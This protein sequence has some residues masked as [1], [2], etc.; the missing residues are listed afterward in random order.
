[1]NG[2]PV[3]PPKTY[4]GTGLTL[5]RAGLFLLLLS[6]LGLAV[7]WDGG[8]GCGGRRGPVQRWGPVPVPGP[9]LVPCRPRHAGLRAAGATAP[10]PRGRALRQL[11]RRRRERFHEPAR[12]AGAH[13]PPLRQLLAPQ[14]ALPR[15]RQHRP[16][17]PL[18]RTGGTGSWG[19]VGGGGGTAPDGSAGP[20]ESPHRAT[21][22]RQRCGVLRQRL[23]APCH[24]A[25]PCQR[26]YEWCLFDACG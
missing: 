2:V 19:G 10:G 11:R 18:R 12:G 8:E 21:W 4:S 7:L 20:Q 25:V 15:G 17:A 24:D 3:R 16:A 5:E 9:S 1:M 14:P 22:A 26:F 23:F 6:R 13:R